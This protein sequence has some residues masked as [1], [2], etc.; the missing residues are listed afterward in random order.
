MNSVSAIAA[1]KKGIPPYLSSLHQLVRHFRMPVF[2][3]ACLA[4][5]A[6]CAGVG[7][8]VG[9]VWRDPGRSD[10][11]LGKTLVL[12]L[13][14]QAEVVTRVEA[15][16]VRQ[17]HEHGIDAQAASPQLPSGVAPEEQQVVA[18]VKA[19]GFDTL[20][21]SRLVDVKHIEREVN[22]Y[23][24]AQVE[25]DLYDALTE[26]RFW[27]ARADTFLVNPTGQRILEQ[28]AE[29]IREFVETLLEEM[30]R[31]KLL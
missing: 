29:R 28:R 20:L 19:G 1:G 6:G 12:V 9:E 11:V 4:L 17:L 5:I 7:T 31:S 13:V 21:V 18:V 23:Q 22:S 14:P 8:T 16:W 24:V 25:T 10:A 3:V 30:G 27:S 26:K 15:E 2:L